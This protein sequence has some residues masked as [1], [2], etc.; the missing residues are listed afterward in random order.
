VLVVESASCWSTRAIHNNW[1]NTGR[2]DGRMTDFDQTL[3]IVLLLF[4]LLGVLLFSRWKATEPKTMRDA[5]PLLL[6]LA[7]VLSIALGALASAAFN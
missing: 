5:Y 3:A 4:A 6:W 2:V 1:P 7:V